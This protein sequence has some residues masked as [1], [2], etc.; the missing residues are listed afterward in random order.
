MMAWT[1]PA[2]RYFMRRITRHAL[3]YTEM[4]TS[5]ALI[6]GDTARFLAFDADEHPVALQLGGSDPADMVHCAQLAENA[7][8][9]EVNINIGCPSERVQ[10]GAFG[11]CLMAEPALVADCVAAM[12]ARVSIPVTV[13]TR[14][15]IDHQDS[16]AFLHTFAQAVRDAGA[17]HL[18]VHARKAWLT[19][20]SPKEN[21]D[22]PPLDYARV[23]RLRNDFPDLPMSV[24]GGFTR[25]DDVAEQLEHVDGV[26]IGREAY[27]NPFIMADIDRRFFSAHG[28]PPTRAEIVGAMRDYTAAHLA[29]GGALKDITRHMLGLYHGQPGGRG[30]RRVLS[31]QGHRSDAGLSV[32]DDA[33]ARVEPVTEEAVA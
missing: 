12:K 20:L 5:G 6:H 8:F 17:D 11:A 13:K 15:G 18:T 24:N 4:V 16:Y 10:N 28:T 30:W 32:L 29:A 1:T 7:G 3:L 23:H 27:R 25:L 14:I 2:Q 31:E 9:D 21:R 26:M 22:V 33:L 19:G